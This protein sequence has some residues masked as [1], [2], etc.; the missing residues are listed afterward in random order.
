MYIP[1]TA[2]KAVSLAM[3]RNSVHHYLNGLLL[4]SSGDTV[5][6]VATDGVRLHMIDIEQSTAGEQSEPTP[7]LPEGVIVPRELVDW[8]LKN[9]TKRAPGV[10]VSVVPTPPADNG[11]ARPPV[12]TVTAG[13]ASMSAPAVDGR[14]P[15]YLRAIPTELSGE[16]G[17]YNPTYIADAYAAVLELYDSR[18]KRYCAPQLQHNGT[19][20]A[21]MTFGRFAAVIMSWRAGIARDGTP[22]A[23]D[24]RLLYPVGRA[25]AGERAAVPLPPGWEAEQGAVDYA[26]AVSKAAP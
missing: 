8:A 23:I 1:R 16:A 19:G 22:D 20:P 10:T 9:S 25:L 6:L 7:P 13:S 2:I 12:I 14:F 11:A 21:L 5:R 18:G 24:P 26:N 17:Q 4:E 15:D 3:A